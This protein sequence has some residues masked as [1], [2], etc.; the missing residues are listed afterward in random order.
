MISIRT[1]K[2]GGREMRE[3]IGKKVVAIGGDRDCSQ[4]TEFESRLMLTS[5]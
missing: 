4:V 1:K 3:P 2:K 5:P